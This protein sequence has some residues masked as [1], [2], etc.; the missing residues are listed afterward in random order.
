MSLGASA[1]NDATGIKR[2]IL[3]KKRVVATLRSFKPI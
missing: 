3:T 2:K 1:A